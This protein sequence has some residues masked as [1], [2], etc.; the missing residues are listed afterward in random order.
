MHFCKSP[1]FLFASAATTKSQVSA[2][3]CG[4]APV[5]LPVGTQHSLGTHHAQA[6]AQRPRVA[7]AHVRCCCFCE[8]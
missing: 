5:A 1:S 3:T 2:P 4:S 6:H 8:A 7:T